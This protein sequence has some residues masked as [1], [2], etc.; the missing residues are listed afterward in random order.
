MYKDIHLT[1]I[2]EMVACLNVLKLIH[3]R[4]WLILEVKPSF[5]DNGP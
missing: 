3:W 1:V 4:G 5:F 2:Y